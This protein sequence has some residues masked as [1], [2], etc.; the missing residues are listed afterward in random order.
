MHL[1][2]EETERGISLV[3]HTVIMLTL[4]GFSVLVETLELINKW[5]GEGI[6]WSHFK[7]SDGNVHVLHVLNYWVESLVLYSIER[8]HHDELIRLFLVFVDHLLGWIEVLLV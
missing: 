3:H 1:A 8:L 5:L 7:G 4:L 6:E 2:L